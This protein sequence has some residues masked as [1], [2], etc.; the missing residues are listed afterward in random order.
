MFGTQLVHLGLRG[1]LEWGH[2][3]LQRHLLQEHLGL[4]VVA[5]VDGGLHLPNSTVLYN[6]LVV[7]GTDGIVQQRLAS[8]RVHPADVV[9]ASHHRLCH[10]ED[11]HEL[12]IRMFHG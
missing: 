2:V 8:L 7:F 5:L 1:H 11:V 10:V 12:M 6:M 4:G 9:C 3:C